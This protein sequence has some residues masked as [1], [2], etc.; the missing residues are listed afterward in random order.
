MSGMTKFY[1]S[2]MLD[3]RGSASEE[4][5]APRIDISSSLG[6]AANIHRRIDAARD[7][8][9]LRPSVS[10]AET[11][12]RSDFVSNYGA[13]LGMLENVNAGFA[14][15]YNRLQE[16]ERN[17]EQ[18]NAD[19][20]RQNQI[21]QQLQYDLE[22]SKRHC[23]ESEKESA[24]LADR[25]IA[26]TARAANLEDNNR[27]IEQALHETRVRVKELEEVSRTLHDGIFTIFGVGSPTQKVLGELGRKHV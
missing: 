13:A 19:V 12:K 15:V 2:R 22:V 1:A 6:V 3:G 18:L 7:N 24:E 4:N 25:V 10:E 20:E 14:D 27:Q 9:S 5:L 8:N 11:D 16:S 23:D 26:E 21:I 17:K